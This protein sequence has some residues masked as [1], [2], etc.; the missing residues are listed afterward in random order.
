MFPLTLPTDSSGQL[1]ILW[2]DGYAFG[3][4]GTEICVFKEPHEVGLGSFMEAQYGSGLKPQIGLVVLCDLLHQPLER[5]FSDEQ[6]RRLLVFSNL[7]ESHGSRPVSV[8]LL[9]TSH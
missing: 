9:Y 4:N 8:R 2:H 3:M 7:P 1:Y 5:C 6:V